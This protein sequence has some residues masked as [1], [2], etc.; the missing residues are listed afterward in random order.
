M[1]DSLKVED[2]NA[3]K[4]KKIQTEPIFKTIEY[5]FNDLAY[6]VKN[7]ILSEQEIRDII[8]RQHKMILNYDYFLE[9][10]NSRIIAQ[11]LFTNTRFINQ[12]IEVSRLLELDNM[13]II[14]IN[15]IAYDYSIIPNSDKELSDLLYICA[16][17]FNKKEV[18]ILS[19]IYGLTKAKDIAIIN[20][21]SFNTETRVHRLNNY[22]TTQSDKVYTVQNIVDTYGWLFNKS[23]F[24]NVFSSV[25]FEYKSENMDKINLVVFDNI[26]LAV[27]YILDSLRSEDIK[28]VLLDYLYL[29]SNNMIKKVRFGINTIDNRFHR[30]KSIYKEICIETKDLYSIPINMNNS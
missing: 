11:E 29:I 9:S 14:T 21:S 3:K 8:L 2:K 13:E 10:T 18:T 6:K 26:S 28:K 5:K 7:N 22:L 24:S 1:F 16:T 4:L 19:G 23:R 25:M 15:K 30:I 27:L 12:F 20:K 17:E